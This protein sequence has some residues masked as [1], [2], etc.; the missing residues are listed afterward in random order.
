MPRAGGFRFLFR[1]PDR[2]TGP[3]FLPIGCPAAVRLEATDLDAN[4]FKRTDI[5]EAERNRLL[6]KLDQSELSR[7]RNPRRGTARVEYRVRD[8][9]LSVNHPG[10]GVGRYIVLGRNLSTGGVSLLH[11][12]YIHPGSECRL[13]LTLPRGGAKTLIGTVVFCRLAAGKIHEVGVQF[14]DKIDLAEFAVPEAKRLSDDPESRACS[15]PIHGTALLIAASEAQKRLLTTRLRQSGLDV[16]AVDNAGAGA[17]QARLLPYRVIVCDMALPEPG[18]EALLKR[19]RENGY[20]APVV[21]AAAEEGPADAQRAADMGMNGCIQRPVNH[22]AMHRM[23]LR[24]IRE[25]GGAE[26]DAPIR[27]SMA[28]ETGAEELIEFFINH[29][30]QA[31][32][33]ITSAV[34]AG[35]A[36]AVRKECHGLKSIAGGYGFQSVGEAAKQALTALDATMSIDESMPKVQ[37]LLNVCSR[38]SADA[39]AGRA[40]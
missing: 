28:G 37:A 36:A 30:R 23:L 13:A 4:P 1:V 35:D 10:G 18:P 19:L 5:T 9:P 40:A 39:V 33:A 6:D 29:A 16:T 8:I 22:D 17:D 15:A 20:T 26:A 21:G 7:P 31:C 38:L 24:V 32:A 12:G 27:S 2:R 3:A 11:A 34:S 14:K 25:S